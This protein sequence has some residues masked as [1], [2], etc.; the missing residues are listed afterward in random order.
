MK[1]Q[2]SDK[3][4]DALE[5]ACGRAIA[6]WRAWQLAEMAAARQPLKKRRRPQRIVN[7]NVEAVRGRTRKGLKKKPG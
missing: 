2:P 6:Q 3:R 4:A 5:V 7:P 1:D